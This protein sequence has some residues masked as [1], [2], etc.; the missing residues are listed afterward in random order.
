[1]SPRTKRHEAY[2]RFLYLT[3]PVQRKALVGMATDEQLN[4]LRE[5][6]L[7]LYVGQPPVSGYYRTKLKVHKD[8]LQS[9]SDRAVDNTAVK[10]QLKKQTQII[11]LI[12]KPH[13]RDGRGVLADQEDDVRPDEAE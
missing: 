1:M 8:L 13:F 7:N 3:N 5:I 2:L 12:L 9:L 4:A 6:A 10:K 11:P